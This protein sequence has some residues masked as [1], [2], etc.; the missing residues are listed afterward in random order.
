MKKDFAKKLESWNKKNKAR[1]EAKV[2]KEASAKSDCDVPKSKKSFSKQ[3][4][5]WNQHYRKG[6][7]LPEEEEEEQQNAESAEAN[8]LQHESAQI[9]INQ[10]VMEW[11]QHYK[12][13]GHCLAN[14][15]SGEKRVTD[16][17]TIDENS[18]DLTEKVNKWEL[19]Y[20]PSKREHRERPQTSLCPRS[21]AA[22]DERM[23]ELVHK[24]NRHYSMPRRRITSEETNSHYG[25]RSSLNRVTSLLVKHW[26]DHYVAA[27]KDPHSTPISRRASLEPHSD[28]S[29]SDET[30][31]PVVM[32]RSL[33]RTAAVRT[34][35]IVK[36]RIEEF[37]TQSNAAVQRRQQ[38][39]KSYQPEMGLNSSLCRTRSNIAELKSK[40]TPARYDPKS[41]QRIC[42]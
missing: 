13:S 29:T 26:D 15:S 9:D 35:S 12:S 25:K 39:P 28:M 40:F 34:P 37:A 36:T 30:S 31:Q 21:S 2:E 23:T 17:K 42:S 1:K 8:R 27:T 19:F 4:Y 16:L 38:R 5:E 3:V 11:N 24:W 32:R 6:K 7:K 41:A 14:Q 33:T 22:G 10:K 18:I 20:H